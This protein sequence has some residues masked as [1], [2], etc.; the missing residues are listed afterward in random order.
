LEAAIYFQDEVYVR[1][2]DLEECSQIFGADRYYYKLC[3]E[4]NLKV[5]KEDS[6]WWKSNFLGKMFSFNKRL[7]ATNSFI[8]DMEFLS[9]KCEI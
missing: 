8:K 3:L 1:T 7:E 6:P 9:L 4:N 5:Q 2:A